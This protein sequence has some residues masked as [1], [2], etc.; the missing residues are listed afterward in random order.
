MV[1]DGQAKVRAR[2]RTGSASGRER[3]GAGIRPRRAFARSVAVELLDLLGA[4]LV[5]GRLELGPTKTPA[6]VRMIP[7]PR[8]LVAVVHEQAEH[9]GTS[10]DGLVFTNNENGPISRTRFSDAWQ[11]A[12][13]PAGFPPRQG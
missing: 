1:G 2:E 8:E 5:P 7:V 9:F 3:A 13:R 6:S 12:A 4:R 10:S 11:V